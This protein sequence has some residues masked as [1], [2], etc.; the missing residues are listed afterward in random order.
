MLTDA[1][2]T[3][4]AAHIRANTDPAVVAALD[5]RNDVLLAELYNADSTFVVWRRVLTPDAARAAIAG[6]AGLAQLDNLTAGKRDSLLWVFS[7]DTV[8]ANAAQRSAIEDLCGT[9]NTLKAAILAAQKRAATNA[10]AVFATGTGTSQSPGT[11]GW[12]GSV[13]FYDIGVALNANP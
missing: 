3:T 2:M 7:G 11:L 1:Q 9:Q 8:P 10:E 13:S 5:V 4:L 6:G 12:E